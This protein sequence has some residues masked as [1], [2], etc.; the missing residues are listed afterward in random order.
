[1]PAQVVMPS[2]PVRVQDAPQ[3]RPAG[4]GDASTAL[5]RRAAW[6]ASET[7]GDAYARWYSD[8]Y[9]T[10][11]HGLRGGS[12]RISGVYLSDA[13]LVISFQDTRLANDLAVSGRCSWNRRRLVATAVL[14]L[15]GP[16]ARGTL[17]LQW[18]TLNPRS[19]VRVTGLVNNRRIDLRGPAPWI[20]HG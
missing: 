14:R 10:L 17:R 7:V 20:P 12:Y 16:A 18:S 15:S 19:G 5:A 1:M 11:G 8:M 4:P 13:P 2:F 3:L 9:G 6:V